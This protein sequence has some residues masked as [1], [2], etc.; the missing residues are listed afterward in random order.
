MAWCH[1]ATSHYLSRSW[2]SS[3]LRCG[4]TRGQWVNSLTSV[5]CGSN[6]KSIIFKLII[7][8]F[9]ISACPSARRGQLWRRTVTFLKTFLQFYVYDL[10]F[11]LSGLTTF[12]LSFEHWLYR[13]GTWAF[14]CEIALR[15]MQHNLTHEKSILVQLM[16][17][18]R[19]AT[20][21]YLISQYWPQSMSLY[22]IY[23]P[24]W[25]KRRT[26]YTHQNTWSINLQK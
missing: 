7:P 1:Q 25:V 13:T 15:W 4:V 6:S 22:G 12:W 3:L 18:F 8:V 10:R 19:H 9:Q 14:H 20:S 26:Y 16:D 2:P 24:K 23:R 21:H 5:R 11:K 17:W